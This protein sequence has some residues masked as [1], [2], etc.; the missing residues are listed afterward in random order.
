MKISVCTYCG[1]GCEIGFEN[2]RVVPVNGVVSKGKLCIKGIFGHQFVNHPDRIR[3][4]LVREEL[5]TRYG[6]APSSYPNFKGFK[7]VPYSVAYRITAEELNR[8]KECYGPHS[9]AFI[10]GA[11]TNC[12]SA[13]LFQRFARQVVGS[14]HVDNCARICHAPSLKGLRAT[15][16]EGAASVPFDE[17]YNAELIFVLGSNTTEAHPIVSHRVIERVRSG[18]TLAVLDVREIGLFRFAKYKLAIPYESNLLFLNA[19]ARVIVERRLYNEPFLRERVENFDE[20]KEAILKDPLSHPSVFERLPGYSHLA[21]QIEELAFE[22]A[23]KRT[24]FMWGLGIT[25]HTDGSYAV[26]A[27]ANLALLTGNVGKEGCGLMPLRGQNNVQGACDVGMLPYY[28]PDYRVPEEIGYKTP[29]IIDAIDDGRIKALWVIGEDIAHVHPNQSKIRSALKKLEFLAVNELFPCEVTRFAHV[30]FGVKSCYEKSGVYVNAER[31]LHLSRPLFETDLPDDWEVIN[32]V[33]SQMGAPFN[34]KSSEEVWN[35]LREDAPKR[36][37]G[38]TYELLEKDPLN[39]PQ[40][41]VTEEGKGTPILYR[42][43]FPTPSGKA[44][45]VYT[46]YKLRGM[47]K[48]LL[49]RGKL[50]GFYLTTGRVLPHYNNANQTGRCETLEKFQ[51]FK[52]DTV[53]ASEADRER[54]KGAKRVIL[55]SEYGETAPLP[56]E[57]NRHLKPGTLFVSFHRAKSRINFLFGDEADELV[58]TARFKSVKVEVEVVE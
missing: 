52:E 31:R 38:A 27:I 7:L 32:G 45:L 44:R 20:F 21:H 11:R 34:F 18:A 28:L 12:E 19:L 54:L 24:L 43:S 53:Y 30:V 57:F 47:V 42:E 29:E 22:I 10:G 2:G 9:L 15:V 1:V 55:R 33:A 17:I 35:A 8:L 37:K 26:M 5:L 46:P 23:T 16:G 25:E 39:P 51:T 3:G 50:S 49:E 41:P 13:Y 36:F 14:P 40:W 58:K 48:E 6:Y 56:L 4:A